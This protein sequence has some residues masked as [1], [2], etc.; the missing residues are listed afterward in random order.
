MD[1]L[2]PGRPASLR[3]KRILVVEDEALVAMMV[4]DELAGAGAVVVGTAATVGEALSLAAA[5]LADGG[6]DVAVLDMDLD[7]EDVAPVADAL[8][9]AGV[10]FLF[11]TGYDEGHVRGRRG[12]APVLHKPLASP[13]L[14]AA[15]GGL[16]A[17]SR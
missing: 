5:A 6:L 7:G 8:A 17:T 10:P 16:V 11:H 4:E 12:A 14:A 15:L 13:R 3:A 1:T 2:I 9:A